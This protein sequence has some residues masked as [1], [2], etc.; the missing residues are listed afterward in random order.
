MTIGP[1]KR[2]LVT[3]YISRQLKPKVIIEQGSYIG[4]TS[5]FLGSLLR[6]IVWE[7]KLEKGCK[8]YSVEM[9]KTCASIARHMIRKAGLEDIVD[10]VEGEASSAL[11]DLVLK[12]NLKMDGGEVGLVL[13][14]H[15]EK[16][17]VQDIEIM[18]TQLGLLSEGA[19]VCTDNVLF[20]GTPDY[21]QYMTDHEEG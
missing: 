19:S 13:L 12:G 2:K 6:D 15:W 3:E 14:D 16:F 7:G 8:V 5:V 11:K 9:D 18:T 17:Y 10:V 21:L 20:L 4:Y 1:H